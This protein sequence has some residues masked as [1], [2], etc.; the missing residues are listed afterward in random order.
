MQRFGSAE[1]IAS[2]SGLARGKQVLF[3][4]SDTRDDYAPVNAEI[5]STYNVRNIFIYIYIF[6]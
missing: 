1:T 4:I 3:S 6:L 2:A 5:L